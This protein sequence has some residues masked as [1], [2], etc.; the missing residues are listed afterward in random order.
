MST[1]SNVY[2]TTLKNVAYTALNELSNH[3]LINIKDS[4]NSNILSSKV[5]ILVKDK[6]KSISTSNAIHGSINNLRNHL[7]N[8]H[9]AMEKIEEIQKNEGLIWQYSNYNC[10]R[11][12]NNKIKP[13]VQIEIGSLR[14]ENSGLESQI[15]YYLT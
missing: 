1:Y 8:L 15:E 2:A 9:Y 4:F 14:R 6:L 12:E 5:N 13:W 10:Y 7:N 11:D 3:N